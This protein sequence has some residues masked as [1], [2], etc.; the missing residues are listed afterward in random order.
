MIEVT[1]DE[2]SVRFPV[3]THLDAKLRGHANREIKLGLRH[4]TTGRAGVQT[5][6][7][8]IFSFERVIDVVEPTGPD[9]MLVFTLGGQEAIARV[10]PED[11]MPAGPKYRF[12][13]DMHK[14]KIFDAATGNHL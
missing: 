1:G 10:R 9:T 8:H 5:P 2:G 4:E 12:E 13:V 3:P 6:G 11:R 7:P 14:A